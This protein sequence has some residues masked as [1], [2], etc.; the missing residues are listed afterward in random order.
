MR[1]ILIILTLIVVASC[2]SHR[3]AQ[4]SQKK[5]PHW[6]H[7][8]EHGHIIALGTAPTHEA[9]RERAMTAIRDQV[10]NAIAV[11]VIS[12]TTMST[13][14]ERRNDV[15]KFID[16]FENTIDVNSEYFNALKGISISRVTDFYWEE[17]GR[18]TEKR[19]V[20]HIK[21]PFSDL[22]L[23]GLIADYE[24]YDREIGSQIEAIE[25]R[26]NYDSVEQILENITKV[27]YLFDI[28]GNEKKKRARG[29]KNKLEYMLSDIRIERIEDRPGFVR[30]NLSLYDRPI[31]TR[32]TPDIFA[33]CSIEVSKVTAFPQFHEV[34]YT[35]ERCNL[36]ERQYITI[37]YNFDGYRTERNFYF[38]K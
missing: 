20:Y 14:E 16:N 36:K 3:V 28:A 32:Q 12:S 17:R 27:N 5:R 25:N 23:R 7:G 35:F 22:E 8:I 10:V 4:S 6:V 29:L 15:S 30:Y 37:A 21:Y 13:E 19:I 9:A 18:G 33:S 31:N 26:S 38:T 2:S 11:Q 1:W 24:R 34:D